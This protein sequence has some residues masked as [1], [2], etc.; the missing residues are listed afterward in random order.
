PVSTPCARWNRRSRRK[1]RNS[2]APKLRIV[3]AGTATFGQSTLN[4]LRAAGHEIALVVTQPDRVAG[5][6][7]KV[8]QSGTKLLAQDLGLEVFQPER[9]RDEGAQARIRELGA[10]VMVVV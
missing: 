1:K 5:R 3:F 9:I 6:G 10:D 8:V 4:Q 2:S 7:L